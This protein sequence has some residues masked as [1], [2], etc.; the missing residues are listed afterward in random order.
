MKADSET[1]AA[2]KAVM[3]RF[4]DAY[5]R[6]DMDGL[7]ALLA[8]DPDVVLYGTGADEKRVGR[9]EIRAQ[10]ERDWSQTEAAAFAYEWTSISAAGSVAWAAADMTFGVKGG[11]QEMTLPARCTMVLEKR[12]G[13][14][15]ITQMHVSFPAAGQAEGESWP[16]IGE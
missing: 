9:A 16:K 6:R 3:D 11:G 4:A 15:L 1:Q 7:L 14:W 2:V 13:E 8:P 5:A 12:G 10:A